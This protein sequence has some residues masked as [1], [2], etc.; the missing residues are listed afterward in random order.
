MKWLERSSAWLLLTAAALA[1]WIAGA[2]TKIGWDLT[3]LSALLGAAFIALVALRVRERRGLQISPLVAIAAVFFVLCLGWWAW[4]PE[5]LFATNFAAEHWSFLESK[6]PASLLLRPRGERLLFLVCAVLSLVAAVDLGRRDSFRRAAALTIGASGLIAACYTLGQYWL[7]WET[8][9]WLFVAQGPDR[10]AGT[11]FH[12]SAA[13]AGFNVA[14]PLAVFTALRL[15]RTG[16]AIALGVVTAGIAAIALP[17]WDAQTAIA[18]AGGLAV[19]GA[20]HVYL[21]RQGHLHP[22][23]TP[24]AIGV[25]LVGVV[26]FQFVT[27]VRLRDDFPDGW[28]SAEQ[29]QDNAAG[30]DA[31]VR[32]QADQRGDRLVAS[33]APPRA[34]AWL[35]SLRMAADNP[36]LGGGP[37]SWVYRSMLYTN[38]PIVNTFHQH[39]QFA[40]N[41]LF[42][43]AAEWGILPTLAWLVIWGGAFVHLA[44]RTADEPLAELPLLLAL[45]GLGLHALMHFPLQLSSLQL[46]GAILLGLAWSGRSRRR[47]GK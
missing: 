30:R 39:R 14:W 20:L 33:A 8:P 18:V 44:W 43:T 13:S 12:H 16:L 26:A 15:G 34:V 36:I 47:E 17:L 24:W 6:Y 46:W 35:T 25:L 7:E 11:Y 4:L 40:H 22:Q 38:E 37:G 45:L 10:Y 21:G 3:L 41:D 29:T 2:R 9:P 23:W 5:P 1:P 31:Y 28:I 32:E 27:I 19:A 42:H